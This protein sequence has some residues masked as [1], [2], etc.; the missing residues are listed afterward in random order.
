MLSAGPHRVETKDIMEDDLDGL[1]AG[2][3][4]DLF[5]CD[6]PW[7]NLKYWQT[8]REKQSGVPKDEVPSDIA[9]LVRLFELACQHARGPVLIEYG[10]RNVNAVVELGTRA[11]LTYVDRADV[12]YGSAHRPCHLHYF[13]PPDVGRSVDVE[14]QLSRQEASGERGMAA[15]R[16]AMTPLA[17]K[18]G[19]VLDPCCGTGKNG[20][21]AAELGMRFRGNE[22]NPHRAEQAIRAL[23]RKA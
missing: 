16:A 20:I 17:V 6:P 5:Y 7:G 1:M 3:K 18:G 11:G 19:I 10:V 15:I 14:I 4:A 9:F 13:Y 12:V 2:S 22:L 8:L 23:R 21:V